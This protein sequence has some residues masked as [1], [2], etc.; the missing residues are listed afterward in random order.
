LPQ[1]T[2]RHRQPHPRHRGAHVA[3]GRPRDEA[4]A[5]PYQRR[6]PRLPGVSRAV[7][8]EVRA[9]SPE[10]AGSRGPPSMPASRRRN[11]PTISAWRTAL[12]T[13]AIA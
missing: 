3:H 8:P 5:G 2:V 10:A 7:R 11:M 6:S 1:R 12:P 9:G 4:T 13:S